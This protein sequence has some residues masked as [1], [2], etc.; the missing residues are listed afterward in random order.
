MSS[1][2]LTLSFWPTNVRYQAVILGF[3]E[4]LH[5]AKQ[6]AQT[7]VLE[8]TRCQIRKALHFL[9]FTSWWILLLGA[10]ILQSPVIPSVL[11][12]P[13]GVK[14][15]VNSSRANPELVKGQAHLRVK[16]QDTP[17]VCPSH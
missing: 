4:S 1:F 6:K 8:A 16:G 5:H 11:P 13:T 12:P 14:I 15:L 17:M 10:K 2:D 9:D 7:I 3:A